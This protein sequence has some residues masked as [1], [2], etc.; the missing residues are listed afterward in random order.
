MKDIDGLTTYPGPIAGP[1][2]H[3]PVGAT[4]VMLSL[5]L[6]PTWV[7][8]S[9]EGHAHMGAIFEAVMAVASGLCGT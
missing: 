3:S 9:T 5:G 4:E 2:G 6:K 1:G 7:G 8:A